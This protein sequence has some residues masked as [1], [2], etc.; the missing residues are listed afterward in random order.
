MRCGDVVIFRT[1]WLDQLAT[2]GNEETFSST[3]PGLGVEG[4]KFLAS[5]GAIAIGADNW[6]IEV[7]PFEVPD[8]V[9]PVHQVLLQQSGVYILENIRT[10]ELAAD[11]VHEFMFVLGVPR[12]VGSVQAVVTPVAIR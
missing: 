12:L 10:D 11:G 4:A 8:E 2:P 5:L 6:G 9:F 1:G 3:E 7:V